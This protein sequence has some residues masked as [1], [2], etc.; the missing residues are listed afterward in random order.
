MDNEQLN[1]KINEIRQKADIVDVVSRHIN[2]IRKGRS[3]VAICPFHNDTNPSLS[4]SKDKQIFKCFV[5]NTGGNVFSFVQKYKKIPFMRAVK[6]VADMVGV[7]FNLVEEKQTEVIDLKDKKLYELLN[8]AMLFYKNSLLSTKEALEYCQNRNLTIDIIN[9]FKIGYSPDSNKLIA[10]LLSKNYSKEDIFRSGVAIEYEG[11]LIDRFA[12]RLIFPITNLDGKIVAFSGR[13]IGQSDMA[14]YVNSPE[15]DLFIKGNTLYNYANALNYIK[16]EKRMYICEGF[17]D[18]IAFNKAGVKNIVALM[19]TA[20]TKEH[21][22]IFKYLGVEIVLALDGDNPGI[23]NA[24]KLANELFD[25]DVKCFV[26]PNYKDAKDADEYLDKYGSESFVEHLKDSI[27]PS[28][29]FNFYIAS[30]LEELEN[31]EN[32]K[33][34]LQKMCQ[35]IAKMQDEDIDIYTNKLHKELG[36]SISTINRLIEGYKNKQ[37]RNIKDEIESYKRTSRQVDMQLRIISQ[38][39]DSPEAIELFNEHLVR[40]DNESFRKIAFTIADYY[41]VNKDN[42]NMDYLVADIITK[43]QTDYPNDDE[44]MKTLMLIDGAKDKYPKYSRQSFEDLIFEIN[45]IEPLENRISELLLASSYETSI[46]QNKNY[47]A[48]IT[49]LKKLI[50]DKKATHAEERKK[51][52]EQ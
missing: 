41:L 33:K 24:N 39:M 20:F 51:I 13:V 17:M 32:K 4:I 45:E 26:I 1:Q 2:V 38:M 27:I 12:G 44:L 25:L 29:E 49:T 14:K 19:G 30:K 18:C 35:R 43:V 36:F 16:Q 23:T 46:E 11:N 9:D 21:L 22:K 50:K 40:I 5:C 28:F 52:N 7:D 10:Y 48:E 31:N 6:E 37:N 42:L 34:F 47:L 15:T 3:Y 8:E